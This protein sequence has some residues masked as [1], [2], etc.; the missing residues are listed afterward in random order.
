MAVQLRTLPE[1]EPETRTGPADPADALPERW[2]TPAPRTAEELDP[3]TLAAWTPAGA[4]VWDEPGRPRELLWRL[5]S[6]LL[7][8]LDGKRQ[9][10]QLRGA[11]DDQV[12]EAMLTRT[13]RPRPPGHQH[14][15]L[16]L[17]TCRPAEDV[18]EL[19]ATVRVAGDA[20][21]PRGN[22]RAMTLAGRVV[23]RDGAW[24]CTA[25]RPL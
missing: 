6:I 8:A 14:R 4:P 21:A 11:M 23:L 15:L 19:C 16:S 13:R 17:H 5:L 2:H 25:L 7:E 10:G 3:S 20:R 18:I 24:R 1:Y 12:Y 9:I 22:W